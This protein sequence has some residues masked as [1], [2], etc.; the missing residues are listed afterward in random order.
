MHWGGGVARGR[1]W[2][3]NQHVKNRGTGVGAGD[4]LCTPW[5]NKCSLISRISAWIGGRGSS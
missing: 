4:S 1:G 3:K 5:S 2:W